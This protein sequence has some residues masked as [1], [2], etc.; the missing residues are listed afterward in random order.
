MC[1]Q[2]VAKCVI[3][4]CVFLLLWLLQDGTDDKTFHLLFKPIMAKV[5]EVFRPGAVVMQCGE[6]LLLS[7]GYNRDAR[8][9]VWLLPLVLVGQM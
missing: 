6:L 7:W 2:C 5:M 3:L 9:L 8:N 1:L 4:I